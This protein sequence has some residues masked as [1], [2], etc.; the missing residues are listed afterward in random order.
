MGLTIGPASNRVSLAA[1]C[2][3]HTLGVSLSLVCKGQALILL[4]P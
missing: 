1:M 3:M 2:Q 4:N